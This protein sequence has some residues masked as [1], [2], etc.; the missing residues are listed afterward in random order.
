MEMGRE[1]QCTVCQYVFQIPYGTTNKGRRVPCPKC[2]E[3]AHR[4]Y[5]EVSPWSKQVVSS[6]WGRGGP[7]GRSRY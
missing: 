6:G 5:Q 4:T 7:Q 1:Y 2:G 3:E